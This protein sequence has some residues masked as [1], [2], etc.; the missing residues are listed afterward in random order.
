MLPCLKMRRQKHL[1]MVVWGKGKLTQ[2]KQ[3]KQCCLPEYA[4]HRFEVHPNCQK[5]LNLLT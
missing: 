4:H 5:Y 2:Q 1:L 3:W